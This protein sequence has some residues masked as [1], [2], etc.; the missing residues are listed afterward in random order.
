MSEQPATNKF[1]KVKCKDCGNEQIIF[2]RA[3]T[4]VNCV[5]CGSSVAKP[6]GGKAELKGEVVGVVN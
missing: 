3:S 2:L 4:D 5:V 1:A 6:T